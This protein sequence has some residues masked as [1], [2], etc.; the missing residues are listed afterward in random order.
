MDTTIFYIWSKDI[1]MYNQNLP[2][3]LPHNLPHAFVSWVII[4][5]D[6]AMAPICH[7]AIM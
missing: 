6:N 5:S 1:Y 7:Q 3:I 2:H 4:G